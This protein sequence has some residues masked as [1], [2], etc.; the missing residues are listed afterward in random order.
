MSHDTT[1]TTNSAVITPSR[2]IPGALAAALDRLPLFAQPRR[3]SLARA[4]EIAGILLIL[5][6]G[7]LAHIYNMFN[8][9]R[10]Q[11]DEGVYTA[12]AWAVAHGHIYPY[13]YTYGHPPLAWALIAAWCEAIGGFF[14]FGTAINTGRVFMIVIFTLSALLVY[15]ITRRLAGNPWAALLALALFSLSPLSVYYQREVL[16]D[17]VATCWMLLAL[18]LLVTSANKLRTIVA[19]AFALGLAFLSKETMIVLFPVFI[20]ATWLQT[21]K[22][23][24]R[25][26]TIVFGY[27][28]VA[29]V[30]T[31]LL[32]A[33]LKGELFPTGTLLGGSNPHVSL[34]TTFLSQAQRGSGQGSFLEQW[35][36]WQQDDAFL[37]LAGVAAMGCNILFGWRKPVLRIVALLALFYLVFLARGGVTFTYYLIPAIPLLVLN[38]TLLIDTIVVAIAQAPWHA[39]HIPTRMVAPA[40]FLLLLLWLIPYELRLNQTNFTANETGPQIAALQWAR[41]NLPRSATIIASHYFWV[42]MHAENGLGSG[43]GAS[44]D[45][46][47]MYWVM[48]TDPAIYDELLHNNW[49]NIDYIMADSDLMIDAH[50]YPMPLLLQALAHSTPIKTFRNSRFWVTVYKVQHTGPAPVNGADPAL[51]QELNSPGTNTTSAP[52]SAAVAGAEPAP[53]TTAPTTRVSTTATAGLNVRSGPG[54]TYPVQGVANYG[55]VLPVQG[56]SNNWLRTTWYG[57]PAWIAGWWTAPER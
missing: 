22:F 19:S 20:Y 1:S 46:I 5:S 27:I 23:Q 44:F 43:A 7:I 11:G 24:R 14:T 56:Q 31:F 26:M 29:M 42:D 54:L 36:F 15:L 55:T 41:Q 49:D 53:A 38:I 48:A 12:A 3:L 37:M 33:F 6:A 51:I 35:G 18:Y 34:L 50:A 10:Y 13:T 2:T 40:A 45:R 52:A 21:S 4:W 17:N 32:L 25:F 16:L 8:Y 39:Y 28:S 47:E 9:P 57:R 30:S